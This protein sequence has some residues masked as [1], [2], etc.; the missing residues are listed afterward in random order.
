MKYLKSGKRYSGY[1][2]LPNNCHIDRDIYFQMF[3]SA[4]I[5]Q[6][7]QTITLH[8]FNPLKTGKIIQK[9]GEFNLFFPEE[10]VTYRFKVISYIQ[11]TIKGTFVNSFKEKRRAFRLPICDQGF[12][13]NGKNIIL[14]NISVSGV[15]FISTQSLTNTITI[16]HSDGKT[17]KAKIIEKTQ[18]NKEFIYRAKITDSN[19]NISQFL[20]EKYLQMCKKILTENCKE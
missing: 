2:N 20:S 17:I 14:I 6:Q 1:I 7:D 19:F 3:F 18:K 15:L 11:D 4:I 12:S 10:I 16:K 8:T 9:C 5:T 13:I